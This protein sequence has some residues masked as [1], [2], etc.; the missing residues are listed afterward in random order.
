MIQIPL[1]GVSFKFS[2]VSCFQRSCS[3]CSHSWEKI[4]RKKKTIRNESTCRKVIFRSKQYTQRLLTLAHWEIRRHKEHEF[5]IVVA[6]LMEHDQYE[7]E[8]HD[9]TVR[10]AHPT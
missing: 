5:L 8:Q 4:K 9:H 6:L 10:H 7:E 2:A 1:C 3:K